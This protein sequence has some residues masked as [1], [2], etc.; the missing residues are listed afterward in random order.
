M[1]SSNY[2]A[3]MAKARPWALSAT[4][5]VSCLKM[6]ET[7]KGSI[8]I[9]E[10]TSLLVSHTSKETQQLRICHRSPSIVNYPFGTSKQG[11]GYPRFGNRDRLNR[12][13]SRRLRSR[14]YLH[15]WRCF[16]YLLQKTAVLAFG[17]VSSGCK[18]EDLVSGTFR[19]D[20]GRV[21]SGNGKCGCFGSETIG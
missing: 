11:D 18:P 21:T 3:A 6:K 8:L 12:R 7:L 17:P 15:R 10:P 5:Q 19:G 14:S 2:C 4:H 20:G 13:R 9:W 1:R 16:S